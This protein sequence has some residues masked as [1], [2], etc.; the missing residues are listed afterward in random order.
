MRQFDV[1]LN[2]NKASANDAPYLVVL[3]SDLLSP[4]NTCVVAP[5]LKEKSYKPIDKLTPILIIKSHKYILS[6]TELAGVQYDVIGDV[7]CNV[8][9]KRDEIIAALDLLFLGF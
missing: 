4:L 5:L 2:P 8:E 1:C 7:V 3:Q 6:V 9:D